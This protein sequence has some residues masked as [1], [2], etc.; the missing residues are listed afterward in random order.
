MGWKHYANAVIQE[1]VLITIHYA[2]SV[3]NSVLSMQI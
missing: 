2:P 1:S 3:E